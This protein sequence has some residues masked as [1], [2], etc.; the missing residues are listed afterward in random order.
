MVRG[1][2][3]GEPVVGAVVPAVPPVVE[4]E[5]GALVPQRVHAGVDVDQELRE[6]HCRR[7]FILLVERKD[8]A[9]SY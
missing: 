3:A 5:L 1:V 6:W 9:S 2:V 7:S 8:V 4:V